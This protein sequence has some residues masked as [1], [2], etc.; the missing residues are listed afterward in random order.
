[1]A[2]DTLTYISSRQARL[3][4]A[5][6][7]Y[8]TDQQAIEALGWSRDTFYRHKKTVVRYKKLMESK[9]IENSTIAINKVTQQAIAKLSELLDTGSPQFQKSVAL[10]IIDRWLIIRA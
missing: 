2:R 4:M 7:I 3:L 1:M 10:S 9:M 5:L 6:M 8:E